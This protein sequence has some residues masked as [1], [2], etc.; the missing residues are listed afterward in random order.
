MRKQVA[1]ANWKMNCT[2]QQAETLLDDVLNEHMELKKASASNFRGA[3]SLP[4]HGKQ[5]S[6]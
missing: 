3:I 4:D 6:S 1:A 2:Y 5:R